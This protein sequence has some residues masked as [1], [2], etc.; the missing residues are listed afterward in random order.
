MT[1][2]SVQQA[3]RS[4]REQLGLSQGDV[5]QSLGVS[6]SFLSHVE[7]G[8]RQLTDEQISVLAKVL[9]LPPDL[10]ALG[11]GRLPD[12]VREAITAHTAELVAV[13]RKHTESEAVVLARAPA[14]VL[15]PKTSGI[16]ASAKLPPERIDAQ[17]T[18]TSYRAH[19]YHTKIPPEAITPFIRAFTRPGE[20]VLD[21]FCGSGMTGVA[22][23]I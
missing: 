14:E 1:N 22:A 20:I 19:S 7:S 21:P 13:V 15:L 23:S 2:W 11:T 10:L 17:K 16:P 9:R 4:R 5:A 6:K 18:S 12:D 8:N 3:L